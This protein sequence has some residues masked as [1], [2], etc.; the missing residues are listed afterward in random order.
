MPL[1]NRCIDDALF[2]ALLQSIAVMLNAISS[3]QK[4]KSSKNKRIKLKYLL[5]YNPKNEIS[6]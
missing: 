6:I 1:F 4:N 3:T 2:K 5:V